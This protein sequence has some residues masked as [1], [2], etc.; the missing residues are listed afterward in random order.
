LPA[1]Q[2]LS[3]AHPVASH[4]CVIALHVEPPEHS[5]LL[6]HPGRQCPPLHHVPAGQLASFGQGAWH[7]PLLQTCPYRQSL[8][9]LQKLLWRGSHVPALQV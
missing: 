3:V 8:S 9:W 5:E 4:W 2:S 7:T 6:R 1:G